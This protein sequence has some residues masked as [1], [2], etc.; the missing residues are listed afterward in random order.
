MS[1]FTTEPLE[2]VLYPDPFLG[3][4]A[5]P[6]KPEELQAG[7]AGGWDLTDLIERM[8][9]TMYAAEGIGL[10]APQV[11]VG[12]RIFLVDISKDK[13]GFMA[14]I[15]PVLSNLDGALVEEEGCLS[16][17]GIRA[18][19]K[20]FAALHLSAV[21]VKGAKIEFDAS[22]LLARVCQHENDHLNGILFIN[23]LGMASRAMLR[24]ALGELEEDYELAQ[25]KLKKKKG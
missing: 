23:K 7:K 16:I 22:D 9:V 25:A 12:L 15:N 18:K 17:P 11:G 19:V 20:R 5:R 10:A 21:D 8:K 24:R 14:L 4:V 3:K 13:S 1:T 2:I 6:V